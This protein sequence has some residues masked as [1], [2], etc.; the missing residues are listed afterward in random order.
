MGSQ[1][2]WLSVTWIGPHS[3]THT[4]LGCSGCSAPQLRSEN[5]EPCLATLPSSPFP[6]SGVTFSLSLD[7]RTSVVSSLALSNASGCVGEGR[8]NLSVFSESLCLLQWHHLAALEASGLPDAGGQEF[9]RKYSA[10]Q[11]LFLRD[12]VNPSHTL[13]LAQRTDHGKTWSP[14]SLS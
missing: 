8:C 7:P 5:S 4:F 14:A 1:L 10:G 3:A 11:A 9:E 6:R 2:P 13:P 12:A